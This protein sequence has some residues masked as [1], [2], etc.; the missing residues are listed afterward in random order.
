MNSEYYRFW[1]VNQQGLYIFDEKLTK[2]VLFSK[3]DEDDLIAEIFRKDI[4]LDSPIFTLEIP[5]HSAR[6]H[7]QNYD[8]DLYL[9]LTNDLIDITKVDLTLHQW[10]KLRGMQKDHLKGIVVSVFDDLEG[11]KV[12][13]NS[14]LQEEEAILLAVQAQTVSSMGRV[15]EFKTGFREPLKVP[16]REELIHM[17][18][19]FLQPAPKSSDPRIAKT[20]RLSNIF[21]IF[22]RDLPH[23]T[24]S[25]FKGF[26]EAFLDEWAWNWNS[27]KIKEH[28]ETY[29][30]KIFDEL[31]EDLRSTVTTS[32][33][34]ST[35]DE[36]E[37][38]KLKVF[39][40]DLL[41]QNAV[42]N[43]TIRRLRERIEDLETQ[44]KNSSIDK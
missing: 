31:L 29:S 43:S 7:Y 28:P 3:N 34:L 12:V 26:L 22:A 6:L 39:I 1:L 24:N 23:V 11:P 30:V 2:N 41:S 32:I 40:M 35:H 4:E 44:I 10:K 18:Y 19:D 20:G 17:S 37:E 8:H 9:L 15:E 5:S 25:K 33:D 13:Y 21:L 42:L 16:N 36:R 27:E 38:A 14:C